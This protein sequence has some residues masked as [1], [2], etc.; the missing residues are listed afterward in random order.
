MYAALGNRVA[1]MLRTGNVMVRHAGDGMHLLPGGEAAQESPPAAHQNDPLGASIR[2][3][4]VYSPLQRTQV[5]RRSAAGDP[6]SSDDA[7]ETALV[8]CCGRAKYTGR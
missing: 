1:S 7:A 6:G 5:S 4:S 2:H 3:G 8:L